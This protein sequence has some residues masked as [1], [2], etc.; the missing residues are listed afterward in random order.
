MTKRVVSVISEE[1]LIEVAKFILPQICDFSGKK[2]S[3]VYV[4][5]VIMKFIKWLS[6]EKVKEMSPKADY[7]LIDYVA[8]QIKKQRK[9]KKKLWKLMKE[10]EEEKQ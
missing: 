4:K 3:I 7:A 1:N 5:Q 8:K 6:H 9:D 10:D 2:D